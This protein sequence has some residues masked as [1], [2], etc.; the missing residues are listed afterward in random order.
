MKT[1]DPQTIV[2]FKPQC[3]FPPDTMLLLRLFMAGHPEL[4]R[5]QLDENGEKVRPHSTV[6][7]D[8]DAEKCNSV[9]L[10]PA[11]FPWSGDRK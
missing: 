4:A 8:A 10:T 2:G 5:V 6:L 3:Y 1:S 9:Y 7:Q 11:K